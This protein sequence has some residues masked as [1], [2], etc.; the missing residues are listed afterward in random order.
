MMR[1]HE[2]FVCLGAALLLAGRLGAARGEAAA[3]YVDP[4]AK[5][6]ASA[7]VEVGNGPLLHT[8]QLLP[9]DGRGRLVGKGDAAA[10]VE[11]LLGN[12]AAVLEEARSGFDRVV[13]VNAYVTRPEAAA[14]VKKAFARKFSGEAKPA[15]SFVTT[16][17]A[18]TDAL[19]ALDAVAVAG[20]DP[21]GAV[22]LLH[23][24][25]LA[26]GSSAHGAILPAGARVYVSGQAEKGDDLG[27]ATRRTLE[28][29]RATLKHLGLAEGHVVQ[30]K[31]FL[32]PMAQVG[33]VREEIAKFFGKGKAPPLALVEWT[34]TLP[35]EIELVAW[36]G[37]EREGEVIEYLTPPGLEA[38]PLFSRVARINRG[39][40]IYLSGLYG[41]GGRD[42][43][44]EMEG[45]FTSLKDLLERSGSDF[46]HLAKATYYIA[47]EE[48]SRKLNEVRPR[49]YD[50]RRPPAASKAVVAGV[51]AEGHRATLDMIAVPV[52][53]RQGVRKRRILYNL[54]GDS[55]LF[56]KKGRRGPGP[57]TA[58][59]LRTVVHEITAPG[60]QVDTLLV[61][62]NAQVTYYPTKVGT[63]RGSDCTPQ[64]RQK[65][66]ATEQQRF[67][68]V[69]ALFEAGTDP[70]AVLLAEARKRGLEALLT[71]RM[72]DAHGNDFLRTAFW[73]EHPEFRLGKGALDFK[74]E[75]V[76]EYV[77]RLIEEA[78]RRYDCDGIEL[79]F[80]RFPT[81]FQDSTTDERVATINGLVRRVRTMLDAEGSKRGRRL[82]LAAR[83]P[84]DYGRSAPRY[85]AARAIG[86]DPAAWAKQ[87]WID[88]LTVSEFL[89][90]RYDL[91]IRP[92]KRLLPEVPVYGG[93]ECAEGPRR[94][95]CLTAEKYRRAA[96]HLWA[97]GADGIYLFNFF[98]TREHEQDPFEPPFE[99]LQDIGD[100]HTISADGRAPGGGEGPVA[101]WPLAGDVRDVSG[102]G[103]HAVN[104]GADLDALGPDG[105][106]RGATGFDGRGAH[107]DVAVQ[108]A[109][110]LGKGDF[111]VAAWVHTEGARED[112][113]GDIVS[114]YDPA[115][116][117]GF[118]LTLKTSHVTFSQANTRHLQFGID[119]GKASAWVDCGRPGKA[120]LVFALAVHAGHL[121]AGTCEPGKEEAGH[122]YR[123]AGEGRWID[124]GAPAPCNAVT[125]LAVHDGQLYA[126]T[127]KYR[128]AGSALPESENPHAGGTVF[129][130]EGGTKWSECGQLP[131]AEAV[132]GLAVYRGRL[133]ASSLYRP[134][135]FFRHEGGTRWADCGT[136]GGKRVE[137]LAVHHGHLYATSYDGAH[138]YRYDGKTWADSGPLG[139]NTQTYSL[140][141]NHGRLHV[142]T[143]PSGRVYRQDDA[144]RWTDAGRLGEEKEVMGLVVHNGRLLAGTL[145]LA[146]VYQY[147]GAERWKLL[148]RLDETPGVKYRR[149]WTAAEYQGRVY[150]STLP[151]G[152]VFAFEAGKTVTWDHE[153]PAGW[154][155]VAAVK[156]GGRLE[157]F[158]DGERVAVS[159]PFDPAS[160]DLT[161]DA[162]LRIGFGETD[163]FRGRLRDVRLYDRAL[164]PREIHTLAH[165]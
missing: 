93:I 119:D 89:F 129:R 99:V 91:P 26:P 43:G 78:V 45:L 92:W 11:Q 8:A 60:S 165:P 84:S 108:P 83:V 87:G 115:A 153:L 36:A 73:R 59:D 137:A 51:A 47:T 158:L 98:T 157:L 100:P 118:H 76:R 113:S 65:W 123:Y 77:F 143:W 14:A 17:L 22:K 145:P 88:F 96:R 97:D 34:S 3:R 53:R 134:A 85:D 35:I 52:P 7:A 44:E 24:P 33:D 29:L 144:G 94:E 18:H 58:D 102:N 63:L 37:P 117:R 12:L 121:Y 21:A 66:P 38:S 127:G 125:A 138:V 67:R 10:Q 112:A 150:F 146:G 2:A 20:T 46:R 16:A 79:D 151:S 141:A 81:F 114:Q 40:T 107:L 28:S 105:R 133:Y 41:P 159:G 13:K 70:Y 130:Y 156:H 19:V 31:A 111:A 54:D 162:P 5:T 50:P 126:G 101:H 32:R 55:C 161:S 74:H 103:R 64:E 72:N 124:C 62:V 155:H 160:Y 69:Q 75:A 61:C 4:D 104:R 27:Q 136:P 82:V 106:R 135:G 15:V 71:F 152:R 147:E 68:N 90:V 56:L 30:V 48:A 25:A 6:G 42:A 149:A 128:L 142:G 95:Q 49:Y 148:A 109:L 164:S 110:R 122:V 120:V 116:R 80:Q 86:C 154:R 139:D 131:G 163:F 23:L 39:P 132:G 140:A 57:I 1:R 9:L